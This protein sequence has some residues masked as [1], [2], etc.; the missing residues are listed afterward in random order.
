[1]AAVT[2]RALMASKGI[3]T[4]QLVSKLHEAGFNAPES[5]TLATRIARGEFQTSFF[6]EC[7]KV[8]GINN[9]SLTDYWPDDKDNKQA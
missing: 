1:M 8:L 5:K 9:L 7:L 2:L 6:F 4:P 3:K